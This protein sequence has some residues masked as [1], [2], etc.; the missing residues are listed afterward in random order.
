MT[1][2][3]E[4][5]F[6]GRKTELKR[7]PSTYA[8]FI[9]ARREMIRLRDLQRKIVGWLYRCQLFL[10]VLSR[11]VDFSHIVALR[12]SSSPCLAPLIFE[13]RFF[14]YQFRIYP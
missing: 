3:G 1:E 12:E 7:L 14:K 11:V 6:G 8:R 13:C 9:G 2:A 10:L 4:V 5:R